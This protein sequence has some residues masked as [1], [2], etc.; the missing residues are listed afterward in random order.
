MFKCTCGYPTCKEE[1]KTELARNR[2]QAGVLAA[3]TKQREKAIA[4]AQAKKGLLTESFRDKPITSKTKSGKGHE[5]WS[6][7]AKRAARTRKRNNI[8]KKLFGKKYKELSLDD[9]QKVDTELQDEI[10][11]EPM[12]Q[13]ESPRQIAPKKSFMSAKLATEATKLRIL[14]IDNKNEAPRTQFVE[15]TGPK[16]GESNGIVD[17]LAIKKNHDQEKT[18]NM[19]CNVND[20][21][22]I[23]HIQVK[24]GS[25]GDPTKAAKKRMLIVSKYYNCRETLLSRWNPAKFN[26]V[27]FKR[28][29]NNLEWEKVDA[30]TIF[31]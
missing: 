18:K 9:K 23:I 24:G 16:G 17:L 11:P 6:E 5:N 19:D 20:L 27:I 7:V 26:Q 4:K 28:L 3:K 8:S 12:T 25:A 13:E 22:D 15:F 31:G 30:K 1:Y 21:L 10:T 2:H 14:Q 29:K